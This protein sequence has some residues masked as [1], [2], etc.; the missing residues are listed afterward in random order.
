MGNYTSLGLNPYYML[1]VMT[2]GSVSVLMWIGSRERTVVLM[3]LLT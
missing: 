3:C 2:G 1:E